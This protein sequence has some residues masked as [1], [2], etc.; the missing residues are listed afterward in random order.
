VMLIGHLE[1]ER[2]L[3][4]SGAKDTLLLIVS[5][6]LICVFG[7]G[8]FLLADD[9]HVDSIWV[10]FA[11][12]SILMVPLFIRDFR[13]HLSRTS[14]VVFLVMWTLLHGITVIC[15][16]RWVPLLYWLPLLLLELV[17]GYS[18]SYWVFG[19]QPAKGNPKKTDY[20]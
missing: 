14:F 11:W 17:I 1:T 5:A 19:V 13:D 15:L 8:S 12:S 20:I 9:Y 10:F 16:M 3:S 4:M 7:V 2:D 6:A 18:V